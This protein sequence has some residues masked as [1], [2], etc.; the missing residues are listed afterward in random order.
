MFGKERNEEREERKSLEVQ[1]HI[2]NKI[3]WHGW[4]EVLEATVEERQKSSKL[5]TLYSL[6]P[7]QDGEELKTGIKYYCLLALSISCL[8]WK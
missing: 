8:V 5:I 3:K 4:E 7:F 2:N 1:N 6:L